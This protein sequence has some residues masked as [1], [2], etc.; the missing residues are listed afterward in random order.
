MAGFLK[1]AINVICMVFG[2][3]LIFYSILLMMAYWL[4]MFNVLMDFSVL[5]F[6]TNKRLYP[7][8]SSEDTSYLNGG[9]DVKYVTFWNMLLI[10]LIGIAFGVAFIY[11]TPIIKMLVYIYFNIIEW[12]G[13]V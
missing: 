3:L 2:V 9:E 6:M 11:A 1:V 8:Y 5:N 7:I 12:V 13:V 10:M 4:D